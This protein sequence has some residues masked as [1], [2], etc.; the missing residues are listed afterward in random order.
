[1]INRGQKRKP[2]ALIFDRGFLID[3]VREYRS[4]IG[5]WLEEEIMSYINLNLPKSMQV[6][7]NQVLSVLKK[8]NAAKVILYGSAAR[9]DY[10]DSSDLDIC[11]EGLDSHYFFKALGECI[12]EC[13][14]SVSVT[15]FDTTYGYFRER[16]LREGKVIYEQS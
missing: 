8:Y 14:R 16:I 15:D 10:K 3:C 7:L 12:M 1:V 4:I 2:R 13:E 6:D 5:L 11:V 9:G